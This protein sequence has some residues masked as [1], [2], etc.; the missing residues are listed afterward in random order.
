MATMKKCP[1]C[2]YVREEQDIAPDYECPKC[3]VIYEKVAA[4]KER[5][6]AAEAEP[7]A[8]KTPAPPVEPQGETK[9]P[10]PDPPAPGNKNLTK[11]PN[12]GALVSHTAKSCPQCGGELMSTTKAIA[13]LV[14]FVLILVVVGLMV[15]GK[16]D[17]DTE[18][19]ETWFRGGDLHAATVAE[20]RAATYANK[21][22]TAS[23]WLVATKWKGA[24]NTP[25]DLAKLKIKAEM[26]AQALDKVASAKGSESLQIQDLAAVL[27]TTSNDLGP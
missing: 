13:I 5:A 1:K 12:C 2:G 21:L 7:G 20:W 11:C 19:N 10:Q 16:K 15:F 22:A 26:L 8:A 17:K 23:D 4:A 3:G 9:P 6:K 25:A 24:L 14:S 27:I 18:F